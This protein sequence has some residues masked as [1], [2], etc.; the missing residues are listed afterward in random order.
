MVSLVP[1]NGTALWCHPS[2][3]VQ[4]RSLSRL[5]KGSAMARVTPK[6]EIPAEMPAMAERSVEQV[7]SLPPAAP[8]TGWAPTRGCAPCGGAPPR[9][10][11]PSPDS[12]GLTRGPG[13]GRKKHFVSL[14]LQ[15]GGAAP[16]LSNIFRIEII[17]VSSPGRYDCRQPGTRVRRES[18]RTKEPRWWRWLRSDRLEC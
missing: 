18:Q 9:R 14:S 16:R 7:R 13:R 3:E 8:N 17:E 15:C 4:A 5:T 6:H 12:P 2:Q 10:I 1:P 11:I